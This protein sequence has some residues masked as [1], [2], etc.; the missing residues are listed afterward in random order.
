MGLSAELACNVTFCCHHP[1]PGLAIGEPDD[2]LQRVIQYSEA[3]VIEPGSRGIL[4]TPPSR[5]M[6]EVAE[7]DGV[8][9]LNAKRKS[10]K[11]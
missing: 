10:A 5:G 4:D 3:P 6:T 9:K 7:C 8:S 1:P 11:P 2:K